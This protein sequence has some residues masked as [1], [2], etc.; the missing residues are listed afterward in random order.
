MTKFASLQIGH[1]GKEIESGW[2]LER[3]VVRVTEEGQD[4]TRNTYFPCGQW[5]GDNESDPSGESG[6]LEL[7]LD[8]C[9][10]LPELK[11]AREKDV[12]DG[13]TPLGFRMARASIPH[14][15]KERGEDA[16][17]TCNGDTLCAMG[18]SDGVGE[19]AKDGIDAGAFSRALMKGAHALAAHTESTDV[20]ELLTAGMS[21]VESGEVQ[22][23][24]T[25]VVA[26]L[27]R[28]RHVMHTCNLG[29]SGYLIVRDKECIYHSPQQEHFFGCPF[30]LQIGGRDRVSDAQ[31]HSHVVELGDVVILGSDGL[32]DNL[33]DH[34]I[35]DVVRFSTKARQRDIHGV[36]YLANE[37]LD[38]A[39]EAS[40]TRGRKT[41]YARAAS[42]EFDMVYT[43][44]KKDDI[45]VVVAEVVDI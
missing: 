33:H 39:Y 3:C 8:A 13:E 7:R 40:V 6:P 14:P 4:K 26:L 2:Y 32:F 30:Q 41:P 11:M 38:L 15:A 5:L 27:D 29:D 36:K 23:S 17:F 16:W 10:D 45:T 25:A 22:G 18:I 43:G 37:L 35:E 42:E 20:K 21:A 19:W 9:E 44:G 24:A 31:Y 34:E 28:E 12:R 1:N